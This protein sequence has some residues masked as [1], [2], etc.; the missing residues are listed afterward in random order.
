MS[1]F[2]LAAALT[3]VGAIVSPSP[4]ARPLDIPAFMA[5]PRPAP[6]AEIRYGEAATQAIDLFRPRGR[7]PFPVVVLIHGGCWSQRTA[8]R[9][10][11][12]HLGEDLAHRG[13]AT[14]SIGYRRADEAGGGYP[15]TYL[16]VGNAIDR[17][18]D[19]A[20]RHRLDLSRTVLVGHSAG[21]HLALWAAS[22]DRLPAASVLRVDAP[23]VPRDVVAI[24]GVGDLAS[25]APLIPGVCGPGVGERLVGEPSAERPDVYADISPAAIPA[26]NSRIVMV[27]GILDRLVP[28]YVAHDY[29][30]SV[31]GKASV[32]LV[33]VHDAGHFDLVAMGAAWIESRRIIEAALAR[34]ANGTGDAN[35]ASPPVGGATSSRQQQP[36]SEHR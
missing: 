28:P 16:D 10:Q 18:R 13:I 12:R 24:A 35:A 33:N 9:E 30:R 3:T 15:G 21:G 5:I 32:E 4:V 36:E 8:A 2:K 20:S 26:A 34:D 7:G 17:L 31:A 11:L 19:E 23:F 1:A 27:S 22:R 6:T 14:W 29:A 25:F